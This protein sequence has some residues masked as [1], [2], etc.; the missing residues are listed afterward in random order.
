MQHVEERQSLVRL[1]VVFCKA[2]DV[3]HRALKR[4]RLIGVGTHNAFDLFAKDVEPMFADSDVSDER[5]DAN[6]RLFRNLIKENAA[7]NIVD[8]L[9]LAFAFFFRFNLA[10]FHA[11]KK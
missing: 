4:F 8:Q 11:V 5:V 9:L 7:S 6:E 1:A 10:F 3:A 2:K